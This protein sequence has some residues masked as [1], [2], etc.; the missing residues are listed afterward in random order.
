MIKISYL[1]PATLALVLATAAQA[2]EVLFQLKFEPGKVY[3]TETEMKQKATLALAGQV[4]ETSTAMNS[5][6]SQTVS[7]ADEGVKGVTIV[8]KFEQIKMDVDSGGMKATFDSRNPQGDL[9][10]IMNSVMAT[11]TRTNLG[12][13]GKVISIEAKVMPG[14]EMIGMGEEEMEQSAR[15]VMDLMANKKVAEG[16]SWTSTSKQ[17][18]GGLTEKPVT[19]NYTLTFDSMVEKDGR[20]LAKVLIEGK[21]DEGDGNLQVTSKELSGQM[22]FDP[23]IGQ[24]REITSIIDLEIGLPEGAHVAEGAPG[25]MPM[26]TEMVSRLKEQEN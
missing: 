5:I 25:K 11:K 26:R 21:I 17:P 7:K 3:L 18:T 2:E 1:Y 4:I 9:A 6:H 8:Q 12:A 20:R 15:D 23:E 13:D 19:I 24:P 22:L 14:M 10:M 16:E